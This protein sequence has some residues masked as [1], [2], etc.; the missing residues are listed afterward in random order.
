MDEILNGKGELGMYFDSHAHL[1]DKQFDKDRHAL[2]ATFQSEGVSFYVNVGADLDSS[3]QSIA[4]AEQYDFIYAAVGIHPSETYRLKDSAEEELRG[5]TQHH[6]VVAV[7]E[8]GL[9]YH[10]EDT[11]KEKQ[12][13][14][15]RRQ[16]LLAQELGLPVIIHDREAHGDCMQII[17][18]VGYHNGVFHC[19][20]GSSEMAKELVKWGWYIS[21]AGPVTF[22]NA[23]KTKEAAQYVPIDRL[24]IETDSPYLAPQPMRGKRNCP[25]YVQ[26]VAEEIARL[27]NLTPEF[28]AHK[29]MENAKK[30]FH[31]S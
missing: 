28:V 27:K 30:F 2:I 22:K 10:Y 8:I 19:F 15:F 3:R 29:T 7:G 18:E 20:S 4:L 13:E 21:F 17:R 6:K 25:I 26:Y 16:L 1:D 11:Q 12:Q 5:L 31:I 9:D 23:A 24:L 14:W